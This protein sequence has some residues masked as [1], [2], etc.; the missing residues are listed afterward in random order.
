[1]SEHWS[2]TPIASGVTPQRLGNLRRWN[3]GLT[4]LHF[5][6]AVAILLLTTDFSIAMITSYTDG[7]PGEG[8]LKTATFFDLRIGWVVALFLALAGLDHLLTASLG[9][10]IYE[11][12]LG[13]GINRFRWIEYSIS[14]TIM[15]VVIAM[16]WSITSI[17][18]LVVVAGAN[19]AM[20]LFG[21]LQ[22]RM[23]PPGR[24]STTMLPF[25]FGSLVGITPWVAMVANIFFYSD[26]PQYIFVILIIQGV[27]FFCFGLNQWLQYR[28]VGPWANYA[29][30]EKTYLVLSLAAKSLLAWQIFAASLIS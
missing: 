2:S 24:T 20:I 16:Y 6:Q 13:R 27:F 8:P 30:G 25:W 5:G 14:A 18:A 3:I 28:E 11:R 1:M 19:I 21:W 7:P 17:N 26:A 29:F 22:E 12:D 4:V 23:N 9:R 15:V 10:K